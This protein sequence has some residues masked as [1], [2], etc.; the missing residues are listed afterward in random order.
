MNKTVKL[1]FSFSD[2]IGA[3]HKIQQPEQHNFS[4]LNV[5]S[6]SRIDNI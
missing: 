4:S 2:E 6:K 3:T 5:I 1:V